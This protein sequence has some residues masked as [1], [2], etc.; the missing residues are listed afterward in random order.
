M[1]FKK[2]VLRTIS[3]KGTTEGRREQGRGQEYGGEEDVREP[4]KNKLCMN[5]LDKKLLFC[6]LIK[7]QTALNMVIN[8]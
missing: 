7:K 4:I 1:R 5:C 6:V 2:E 8:L 3:G